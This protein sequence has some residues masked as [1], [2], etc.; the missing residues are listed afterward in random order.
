M[1]CIQIEE[2]RCGAVE[3]SDWLLYRSDDGLSYYK[4]LDFAGYEDSRESEQ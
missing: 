2:E 4:I 3:H 1:N